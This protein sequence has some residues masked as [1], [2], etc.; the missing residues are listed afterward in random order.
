VSGDYFAS[1]EDRELIRGLYG[2]G[3]PVVYETVNCKFGCQ[4]FLPPTFMAEHYKDCPNRIAWE[5]AARKQAEEQQRRENE[6]LGLRPII[7]DQGHFTNDPAT[8]IPRPDYDIKAQAAASYKK[9]LAA[10]SQQVE[11]EEVEDEDEE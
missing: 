6:K 3:T 7:H 8:G 11:P 1:D 2:F 4:I 9:E 10:A 5:A